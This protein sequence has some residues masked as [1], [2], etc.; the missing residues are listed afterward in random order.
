MSYAGV[1]MTILCQCIR[2]ERKAFPNR[3]C[4]V[5]FP[6]YDIEVPAESL[7]DLSTSALALTS[8]HL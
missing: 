3:I 2:E 1:D 8:I 6:V 5:G 4:K 7:H